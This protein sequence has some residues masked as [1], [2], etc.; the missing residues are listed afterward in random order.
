VREALLKHLGHGA[1][2]QSSYLPGRSGFVITSAR[3]LPDLRRA[4]MPRWACRLYPLHAGSGR[5]FLE[6]VAAWMCAALARDN[7]ADWWSEAHQRGAQAFFQPARSDRVRRLPRGRSKR[8]SWSRGFAD[9]RDLALRLE[10]LSCTPRPD[11]HWAGVA[12]SFDALWLRNA[13]YAAPQTPLSQAV[14]AHL[15]LCGSLRQRF[16]T[17]PA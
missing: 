10:A 4:L 3:P 1:R 8:G 13:L 14:F 17:G 15:T 11:K 12:R 5:F 9:L 2:L 6:P 16:S 7:P